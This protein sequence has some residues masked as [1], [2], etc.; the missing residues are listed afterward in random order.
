MGQHIMGLNGLE[1]VPTEPAATVMGSQLVDNAR[2][3]VSRPHN[4]S[5]YRMDCY[6]QLLSNWPECEEQCSNL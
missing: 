5:G 2:V 3:Q 6:H 1:D 4:F